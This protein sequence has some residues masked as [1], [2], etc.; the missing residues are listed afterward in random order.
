MTGDDVFDERADEFGVTARLAPAPRGV[1][2]RYATLHDLPA[3]AAVEVAAYGTVPDAWTELDWRFALKKLR[4][5][6]AEVGYRAAGF[7]AGA[8]CKSPRG[9]SEI[10]V[11]S[12][13]VLPEYRRRGVGALLVRRLGE[14]AGRPVCAG[15]RED[16]LRAQVW[17]RDRVG[18]RCEGV[19]RAAFSDGAAG[20]VFRTPKREGE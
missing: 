1:L 14:L 3:L 17:L 11:L 6:V 5:L 16:N 15:V 20:Y 7:A 19:E 10:Q 4:V 2:T 12:V 8:K 18:L 9:G 13:A